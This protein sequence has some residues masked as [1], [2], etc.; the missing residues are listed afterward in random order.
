MGRA[1]TSQRID[2]RDRACPDGTRLELTIS[3]IKAT[4]RLPQPPL[5]RRWPFL[6]GENYLGGMPGE[7]DIIGR[8]F[9]SLCT[10]Q[11]WGDCCA[12]VAQPAP[13]SA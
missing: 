10:P 5:K 8:L 3:P 11:I 12:Y 6:V 7:A 4:P 1:M 2:N 9:P 13:A